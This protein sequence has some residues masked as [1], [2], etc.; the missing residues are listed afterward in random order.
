MVNEDPES[1]GINLTR[2]PD[3]NDQ[4]FRVLIQKAVADLTQVL[5]QKN[6]V[7]DF[8]GIPHTAK[9]EFD[10]MSDWIKVSDLYEIVM[11]DKKCKTLITKLS[12]KLLW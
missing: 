5:V 9:P 2:K 6:K 10:I 3:Q 1:K 8:L 7:M 4:S 12:N 11:D